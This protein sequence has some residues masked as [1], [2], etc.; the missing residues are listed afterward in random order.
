MLSSLCP[1]L[2]VAAEIASPT[3]M[4]VRELSALSI[5]ALHI[6]CSIQELSLLF[7]GGVD[8]GEPVL[9]V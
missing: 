8:T 5:M 6:N 7:C 9:K 4:R 1:W 2:A 3:D